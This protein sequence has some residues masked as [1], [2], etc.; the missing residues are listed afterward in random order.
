MI[1]YFRTLDDLTLYTIDGRIA[2]DVPVIPEYKYQ[3]LLLLLMSTSI[4]LQYFERKRKPKE[5]NWMYKLV[6]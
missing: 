4:V 1:E 2:E 6:F 5:C 3:P